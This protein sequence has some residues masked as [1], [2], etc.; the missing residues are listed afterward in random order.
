MVAWLRGST[1][2]VVGIFGGACSNLF[3]IE[4]P[5]VRD[6]VASAGAEADGGRAGEP[7]TTGGDGL[8]DGGDRLTTEG[9]AGAAG[10]EGATP[11]E[12]GPV[13]GGP[14]GKERQLACSPS[15][16]L[17]TLECKN[18]VWNLRTLCENTARCDPLRSEC[19]E[20]SPVCSALRPACM[21][22]YPILYDC[23]A[24]PF[25][26][27]QL[28][29][30]FECDRDHC[31]PGPK[32]GLAVHPELAFDAPLRT[33]QMPIE[34]CFLDAAGDTALAAIVRDEAESSWGR[35]LDVEFSGWSECTPSADPSRLE[36]EFVDDCP[37]GA[38]H[39]VLQQD[40]TG[41]SRIG[42]CRT[43]RNLAGDPESMADHEALLRFVTRHQFG[44]VL[45][46]KDNFSGAPRTVMTP[47]LVISEA[48]RLVLTRDALTGYILPKHK[49]PESLVTRYGA[50]VSPIGSEIGR[51]PCSEGASGRFLQ[52]FDKI[53]SENGP[54]D[55]CLVAGAG[56]SVGLG[57][58][59]LTD[60]ALRFAMPRLRW[61]T[62]DRCVVPYGSPSDGP[63]ATAACDRVGAASQAW[64]FEILDASDGGV[65]AH[66][67]FAQSRA[68]LTAPRRP[69]VLGDIPVLG[70]CDDG[71]PQ[72]VFELRTGGKIGM[73]DLCLYWDTPDSVVY[74]DK[75]DLGYWL[76][77]AVETPAG[78]A[79]TD[80]GDALSAKPLA[81]GADPSG[82]PNARLLPSDNQVFDLAF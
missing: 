30:P 28:L 67:R 64:K 18:G 62:P 4:L 71:L 41:V 66:L 10:A 37:S 43:F 45:G 52:V 21:S 7:E 46:L 40:T 23:D 73:A 48:A 53:V 29:C 5:A 39:L 81:G 59:Q 75:C 72:Q 12:A 22:G 31:V 61:S 24:N 42:F 78:L 6:D 20:L 50:C 27:P 16:P 80:D 57:S 70:R 19:R 76:S 35:L 34:V 47:S 79:L 1:L 9:S 44:H 25:D 54:E 38:S 63:I 55:R 32:D 17:I 56:S 15:E 36:L 77:G 69:P 13:L 33:H 51:R 2:L 58:C 8:P 74:F 82:D 11:A 14:C 68:C 3:G 65:I 49:P 26:P 60:A